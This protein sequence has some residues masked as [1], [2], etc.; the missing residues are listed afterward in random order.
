VPIQAQAAA[1]AELRIWLQR[2]SLG[3]TSVLAV[4]SFRS[5]LL[6]LTKVFHTYASALSSPNMVI[7]A[8]AEVMGLYFVAALLLL[9]MSLPVEYRL[10]IT[11]VCKA[12]P[13]ARG[14]TFE[15]HPIWTT[16]IL[17]ENFAYSLV[18]LSSH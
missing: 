11:Q 3:L 15:F 9:R 13:F 14:A 4:L 7:L 6:Q 17:V 18:H 8:L 1:L 2:A 12:G 10:I 5:F 16:C